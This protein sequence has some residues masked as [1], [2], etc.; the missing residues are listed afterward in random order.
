MKVFFL[1]LKSSL[2]ENFINQKYV[3]GNIGNEQGQK[4]FFSG[5]NLPLSFL[6]VLMWRVQAMPRAVV[7]L[8]Q[9]EG[10]RCSLRYSGQE[11]PAEFVSWGSENQPG[12]ER[13]NAIVRGIGE[14]LSEFG[15]LFSQKK[16]TTKLLEI[17]SLRQII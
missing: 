11:I 4:S 14:V 2:D 1:I 5:V 10:G 3:R 13:N 9:V 7:L 17:P 6:S 12:D 8:C 16:E 15:F